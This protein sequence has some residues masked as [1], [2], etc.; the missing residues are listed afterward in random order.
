MGTDVNRDSGS[1]RDENQ[2]DGQPREDIV[3]P[4]DFRK[5]MR[6]IFGPWNR[7]RRR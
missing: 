4:E 7:R 3:F 6:S 2:A 5:L 1:E